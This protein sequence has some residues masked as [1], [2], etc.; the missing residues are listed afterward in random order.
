M[1]PRLNR[2]IAL[3][4]VAAGVIAVT[5][6]STGGTPIIF[7]A[8]ARAYDQGSDEAPTKMKIEAT[9]IA[10]NQVRYRR[11]W[12]DQQ[13]QIAAAIAGTDADPLVLRWDSTRMT[14]DRRATAVADSFWKTLPRRQG[15]VRTVVLQL[16]RDGSDIMT[17]DP[18]EEGVCTVRSY[19]VR[20]PA[21]L[22]DEI[23]S[24]AGECIVAEQFGLPG[25]GLRRW[26]AFAHFQGELSWDRTRRSDWYRG[27]DD[28]GAASVPVWWNA[29]WPSR[30]GYT[31]Y[32]LNRLEMA[33]AVGRADQ[34]VP[35]AGAG[36]AGWP[37]SLSRRSGWG[38]GSGFHFFPV[39][40]LP[41]ELLHA[42]GPEKFGEIWTSDDPMAVSYARAT[43]EPMDRWIMGWAQRHLGTIR[44]DNGLSLVGWLGAF[45][46]ISLLALLTRERI[47]QRV[48]G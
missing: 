8:S 47:R 18:G 48:I 20:S 35:A 4:V 12:L 27:Q 6:T 28:D 29:G 23:R 5:L 43:G 13:E 24:R 9:R 7:L 40:L 17:A 42:V 30:L 1:A 41:R 44:R 19:A 36:E 21:A 11:W 46:W 25:R 3:T 33:C 34:C 38:L 14:I 2:W 26:M 22:V 39:R 32:E 37:S 15:G 10:L 16:E 31:W 45:I